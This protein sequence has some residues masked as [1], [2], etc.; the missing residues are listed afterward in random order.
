MQATA[1]PLPIVSERPA[2]VPARHDLYVTIHKALRHWMLDTLLRVGSLEV[3][4]EAE[5]ATVLGQV[6][7]LLAQCRAHIAHENG[8]VHPALEAARA[9][10]SNRIANEHD[11]HH[12]AIDAL[13]D[14]TR[15]LRAA[16]PEGRAALALHL[17][18]DLALFV[19]D[20]FRHMHHEETVHNAILWARYSDAELEA[21]HDRLLASLPPQEVFTVSRWMIPAMAPRE[22]AGMLSGVRAHAPEGVFDALVAHVRPHLDATAWS[23]LAP[24]IGAAC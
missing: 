1:H 10:T 23:R 22:R 2:A 8:F 17:Y 5:V 12:E 21:L 20:N 15:G 11:E 3:A 6:E 13:A 4:D 9:G 7:A 14:A 19:A 18:R 16:A 24:A